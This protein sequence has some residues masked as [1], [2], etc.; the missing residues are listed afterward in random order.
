MD[1]V[2]LILQIFV[3]IIIQPKSFRIDNYLYT[4]RFKKYG[5]A[6][7]EIGRLRNE[8]KVGFIELENQIKANNEKI[9]D[10]IITSNQKIMETM[11]ST[12]QAIMVSISKIANNTEQGFLAVEEA[13]EDDIKGLKEEIDDIKSRLD[14]ANL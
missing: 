7:N 12:N 10:T 2:C 13:L 8:M 11:R 5:Q 1:W 14:K 4:N 9:M 6:L 3:E